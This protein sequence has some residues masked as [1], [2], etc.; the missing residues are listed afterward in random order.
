MWV[1]D[2]PERILYK[3]QYAGATQEEQGAGTYIFIALCCI[4]VTAVLGCIYEV[5]RSARKDRQ[6]RRNIAAGTAANAAVATSSQRW[7]PQQYT[8]SLVTVSGVKAIGFKNVMDDDKR[9]NGT[10]VKVPSA[11]DY[12][13]LL[14]TEPKDLTNDKKV[15]IKGIPTFFIYIVSICFLGGKMKKNWP[16]NG[17][18]SSI[19]RYAREKLLIIEINFEAILFTNS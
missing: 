18:K 6:R 10:H 1:A 2:S 4:F 16:S 9:P 7:Q 14:N 11:K 17:R 15:H 13:P 8:E 19:I 12:K 5:W 3:S